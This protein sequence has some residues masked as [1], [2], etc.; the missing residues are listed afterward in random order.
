MM[1]FADIEQ[2]DPVLTEDGRSVCFYGHTPDEDQTFI[3]SI[4]LPM[5]I[6]ED[7]F[8]ELLAEW[9]ELGWQHWMQT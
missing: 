8:E 9:R 1:T 7:A 6:E 5:V 2:V 4:R 3:W